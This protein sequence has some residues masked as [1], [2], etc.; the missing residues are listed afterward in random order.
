M[1][2]YFNFQSL[3]NLFTR[4]ETLCAS[5]LETTLD[6]SEFSENLGIGA[7]E[8]LCYNKDNSEKNSTPV[9]SSQSTLQSPVYY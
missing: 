7:G 5:F 8:V 1:N 4:S 9:M 6:N 3:K 2:K